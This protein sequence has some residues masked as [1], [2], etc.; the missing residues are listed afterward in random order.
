ML[1]NSQSTDSLTNSLAKVVVK[2]K[3]L[4]TIAVDVRTLAAA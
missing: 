3:R 2:A 1:T 4:L